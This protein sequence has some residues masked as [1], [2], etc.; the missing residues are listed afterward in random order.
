MYLFIRNKHFDDA[1]C[2]QTIF[3]TLFFGLAP[4]N[5]FEWKIL[6]KNVAGITDNRLIMLAITS[7]LE[8]FLTVKIRIFSRIQL[9][10][11]IDTYVALYKQRPFS[12]NF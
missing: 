12:S 6:P 9:K 2:C 4:W 11:L 7:H 5:S 8:S 10:D 3:L 1:V